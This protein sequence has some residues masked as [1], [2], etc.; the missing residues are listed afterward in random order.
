MSE[1]LGKY[2]EDMACDYLR[3]KGL[4]II[5]RN[6]KCRVG[7][8]DII[9]QDDEF[10]VFAEVKLR[11]NADFALAREFVTPS[12]QQKIIKTA[13]LWLSLN[14]NDRQPRFDVIEIYAPQGKAGKLT[15]NH[16]EAAFY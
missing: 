16:L 5:A 11:K 15:I 10:I 2:G 14:N 4:E 9:A 1:N 3:N 13:Q 12:K 7:E 6:F 8:I